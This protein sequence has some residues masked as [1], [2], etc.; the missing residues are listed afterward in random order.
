MHVP[1]AYCR[2]F[3]VWVVCVTALTSFI[4]VTLQPSDTAVIIGAV[5]GGVGAVLIIVV[6]VVVLVGCYCCCCQKKYTDK[7][8]QY[9]CDDDPP[10]VGVLPS[11]LRIV[12]NCSSLLPASQHAIGTIQPA[13]QPTT[14]LVAPCVPLTATPV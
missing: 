12:M 9:R 2:S 1:S 10:T 7:Y 3:V 5:V 11:D 14:R 13:R 4:D 8:Q 6:V